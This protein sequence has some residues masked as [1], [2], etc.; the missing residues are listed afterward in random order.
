MLTLFTVI[1]STRGKGKKK[2]KEKEKASREGGGCSSGGGGGDAVKAHDKS[3]D[4]VWWQRCL[5][6]NNLL[7]FGFTES[8][9]PGRARKSHSDHVSL[10]VTKRL[11]NKPDTEK[12]HTHLLSYTT[13]GKRH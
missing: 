6:N 3:S 13:A 11:L 5:L 12:K 1:G 10:Q 8:G 9:K 2:K 4:T 7:R